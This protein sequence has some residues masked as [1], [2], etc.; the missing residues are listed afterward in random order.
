MKESGNNILIIGIGNCG[1]TDDGLGWAF[2]DRIKESLPEHMDYAY[3]YQLQIEDAELISHYRSVYFVDAH[4][5]QWKAGFL[6]D[7]CYPKGGHGFS[8][9]ALEP[10]TVVYLSEALYKT[11]PVSY[12]LGISGFRFDLKMGLTKKAEENL[13]QAVKFFD[14]NILHLIS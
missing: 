7:R 14:E 4:T 2:V 12:I 5:Q 8:T 13:E 3:R 11:T 1:R 6:I 10:A 9:H